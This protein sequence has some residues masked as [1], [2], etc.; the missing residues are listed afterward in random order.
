MYICG[1]A[2]PGHARHSLAEVDDVGPRQGH[3][4]TRNGAL[5]LAQRQG[6]VV[7]ECGRPTRAH[8]CLRVSA[9]L[10]VDRG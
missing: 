4:T 9:P 3:R 8:I 10:H 7:V 2:P 5:V 6:N 1:P